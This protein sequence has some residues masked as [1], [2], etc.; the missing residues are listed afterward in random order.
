MLAVL[1]H[2]PQGIVAKRLI[3][4]EDKATRVAAELSGPDL[5]V[6]VIG[7]TQTC[8]TCGECCRVAPRCE[9]RVAASK[10]LELSGPCE[11]LRENADGTATC[12]VL[13]RLAVRYP[14]SLPIY[15]TGICNFPHRRKEIACNP[16]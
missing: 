16:Q 4:E 1:A 12:M 8:N 9:L 7:G 3:A 14:L 11:L 10:P 13:E 6:E 2:G 5:I 15:V